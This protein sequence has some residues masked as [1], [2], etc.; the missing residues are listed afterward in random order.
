MVT[1]DFQ[2]KLV[3]L[4]SSMLNFA[5]KLTSDRDRA[6]DLLQDT[7]LRALDSE[8]YYRK[9]TNFK[10]WVMRIMHNLFINNVRRQSYS[11]SVS[12]N[13]GDMYDTNISSG[14]DETPDC[15]YSVHEINEAINE[16]SD[17]FRIPFSLFVSGYKYSEISEKLSLPVGTVK[18]RIYTARKRL[19]TRF[20]GY[21]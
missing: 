17:D 14:A 4:Q 20:A 7:T 2:T 13:A 9:D 10:A 12:E 19:Q 5:F 16:F 21:C 18:S 6:Y 3:E 1:Q 15:I 11:V 8:D